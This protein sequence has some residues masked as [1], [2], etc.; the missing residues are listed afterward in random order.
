M[1]VWRRQVP[2]ASVQHHTQTPHDNALAAA[3]VPD[4]CSADETEHW[5][6]VENMTSEETAKELEKAI[7]DTYH[8]VAECLENLNKKAASLIKDIKSGSLT[9]AE[10]EARQAEING[11][12]IRVEHVEKLALNA[13]TKLEEY[14]KNSAEN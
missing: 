5:M 7:N 9:K 11:L 8:L 4:G 3:P 13:E 1:M 6:N 12:R 14:K 10:I 2:Q